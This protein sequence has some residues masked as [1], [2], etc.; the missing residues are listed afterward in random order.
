MI[1]RVVPLALGVTRMQL[2]EHQSIVYG[3][4]ALY[5]QSSDGNDEVEEASAM[6]S[7]YGSDE[8]DVLEDDIDAMEET[9]SV[10]SGDTSGLVAGSSDPSMQAEQ[11]VFLRSLHA[12][13]LCLLVF[14]HSRAYS[15]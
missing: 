4:Q 14:M 8:V 2:N 12:F 9:S 3:M 11:Q 15:A 10:V 6:D 7:A 13:L 1:C 5:S